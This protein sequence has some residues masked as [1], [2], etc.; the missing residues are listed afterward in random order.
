MY[1]I[2]SQDA[3]TDNSIHMILNYCLILYHHKKSTFFHNKKVAVD[4]QGE[5]RS[6]Y[7]HSSGLLHPSTGRVLY[8]L[9]APMAPMYYVFRV[10]W[11]N[12]AG[13]LFAHFLSRGSTLPRFG[14]LNFLENIKTR[15]QNF[16]WAR[17]TTVQGTSTG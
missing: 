11:L 10:L 6:W 14:M 13:F 12:I 1:K 4:V 16:E 3:L 2:E 15:G 9:A 8:V 7:A 17:T 5:A